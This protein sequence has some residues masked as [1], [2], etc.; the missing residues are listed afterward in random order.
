MK[1]KDR[2]IL[3]IGSITFLT[4]QYGCNWVRIMFLCIRAIAY[5]YEAYSLFKNGQSKKFAIIAFLATGVIF[6][7]MT[8]G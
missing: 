7:S 4:A 2:G 5:G 8:L 6:P 1:Y 3:L